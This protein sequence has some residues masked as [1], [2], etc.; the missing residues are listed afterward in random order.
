M[1]YTKEAMDEIKRLV[2]TYHEDLLRGAMDEAAN[3]TT[4][5]NNKIEKYHV[6]QAYNRLWD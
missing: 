6:E 3:H 5:D 4:E 1:E 2:K